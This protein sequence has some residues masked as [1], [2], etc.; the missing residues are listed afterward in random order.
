MGGIMGCPAGLMM[1][2]MG[3]PAVEGWVALMGTLAPAPAGGMTPAGIGG[4]KLAS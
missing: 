1:G 2:G 4:G 3:M